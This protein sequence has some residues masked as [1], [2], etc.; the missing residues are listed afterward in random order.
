VFVI[1]FVIGYEL[2]FEIASTSLR[3]LILERNH[4]V[5]LPILFSCQGADVRERAARLPDPHVRVKRNISCCEKKFRLTRRVQKTLERAYC[6]EPIVTSCLR[7]LF[8]TLFQRTDHRLGTQ[9]NGIASIPIPEFLHKLLCSRCLPRRTGTLDRCPR[10]RSSSFS[11]PR[12][13]SGSS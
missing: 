9:H 8:P 11:R 3:S 2:S 13:P 10:Q 12:S 6:G 5:V 4:V 1:R 7:R